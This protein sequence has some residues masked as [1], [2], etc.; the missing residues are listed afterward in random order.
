MRD[1]EQKKRELL[2]RVDILDVV[3]EH[4][5]LKR[6][7][8]RWV[9]LCPFHAE[10]TPSFTVSPEQ[11]F[12]KCF[13]CGQGGDVFSFIQ[14][15][16]NV[17]FIEAMRALADRVGVELGDATEGKSA[18][19]GRADLA[20]VNDWA[21]RFFRSRLLD[22]SAGQSA[23]AYIRSRDISEATEE[24]F[25]LGLASEGTPTLQ[26]A[27]RRA[28]IDTALMLAADLV[29]Q[30][31]NGRF[32]DTFRNRLMFPIRDATK[33]VIGFGGRTLADDRAK[34]LN[35]SQ[36]ALFDKGRS[37]YG[38][39]LAREAIAQSRRV[40]L[41][42]GYTDC[43]A[44]HQA[45]VPETVAT[46]G[47]ALTEAQVDLLRRYC[48][49]IIL[50]FDSDQAGEAAAKRAIRVVL[51][52]CVTVLL[53]RI[54]EGKDP[55]EF[56]RH[57]A[58]SEFS[59]LLN[60]SV[61]GLEFI[62]LQTLERYTGGDSDARRRDAIL[63][64]LRFVAEAADTR[65]VDVIQRGL[66]VNQVAHYLRID[67]SEVSQLMIDLRPR[68][69]K[70]SA[71]VSF[72]SN[73]DRRPA[74]LGA[75]QAAW[76]RLLEVLLNQPDLWAAAA[77]VP[78]IHRI[79]DERNRRIA[80]VVA[81]LAEQPGGFRLVDVLARFHE[82]EDVSRVMELAQRGARR[83]NHEE[84]LRQAL[85]RIRNALQDEEVEQSRLGYFSG[86][87]PGGPLEP[88]QDRIAGFHDRLREHRRYVPRRLI[89]RAAVCVDETTDAAGEM[90]QQ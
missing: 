9:G 68:R 50:L 79:T 53:A 74:P 26:D 5:T 40:V 31:D 12:F 61:D 6:S 84:T 8:R 33:R 43:L 59:D 85:E 13:G 90:E 48:D 15:R 17:P 38:I 65:A 49:T 46:L 25:G 27:A 89:R 39:D 42:E 86:Q 11:G 80:G 51:P 69:A 19:P 20:R 10:K 3:A 2:D 58:A 28:G 24:R 1:F 87:A 36:N 29:R 47:T 22:E 73:Q 57:A 35:T 21:L 30:G 71:S 23:R 64:Y 34:Y 76:T 70:R 16:E 37:V 45:G 55:S 7:G 77:P 83:G 62:W 72:G 63:D 88:S 14:L 18:G 75:E 41:V 4:V 32:Y 66:L 54:V 81:K 44:A 56:L 82:T 67:R 60:R 78:D 52:R